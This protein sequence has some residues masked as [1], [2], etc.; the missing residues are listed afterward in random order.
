MAAFVESLLGLLA[1]K[2]P[3]S[4]PYAPAEKLFV[5]LEDATQ[6]I[7]QK[8][9]HLHLVVQNHAWVL[10]EVVEM[11]TKRNLLHAV[12]RL[13]RHEDADWACVLTMVKA[14]LSTKVSLLQTDIKHRTPL[15]YLAKY[16]E[17]HCGKD[18]G[19]SETARTLSAALLATDSS[20][21]ALSVRDFKGKSPQDY[22][23][24]LE[25]STATS[26]SSSDASPPSSGSTA[27]VPAWNQY[28]APVRREMV[29]LVCHE[30]TL[31]DSPI[32]GRHASEMA[33]SGEIE[34]ES[35]P[36]GDGGQ[37]TV[38]RG[39]RDGRVVAL[40]CVREEANEPAQA[41]EVDLMVRMLRSDSR[42][43]HPNLVEILGLVA[44]PLL[45]FPGPV[46]CVVTPFAE[47]G[48]LSAWLDRQPPGFAPMVPR[49]MVQVARGLQFLHS[50]GIVHND[51]K[52]KNVLLFPGGEEDGCLVPKL[53]DFGLSYVDRNDAYL[54]TP[55]VELSTVIYLAPER[56]FKA[57]QVPTPAS[58]MF[59]YGAT[60]WHS[61][62]RRL[63]FITSEPPGFLRTAAQTLSP[64]LPE[65]FP[66]AHP[67]LLDFINQC[68]D[69]DPEKRPT[70][71][72][73]I[74][75]NLPMVSL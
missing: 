42:C 28:A 21:A 63:P 65:A 3:S 49:L 43:P 17:A 6:S 66:G 58:D 72:D 67:V 39:I 2:N 26:P 71:F 12:V 59:S 55:V 38:Y 73:P 30:A 20:R 7:Q 74:L 61:F 50:L 33:L 52:P 56:F 37:G 32:V 60:A 51:L 44:V 9:K 31:A 57:G 45:P 53:I 40:K 41:R 70:K 1:G 8:R 64:L 23:P 4:D 24:S 15:H 18:Q 25:H 35:R 47:L 34:V 5:Q 22:S 62:H 11:E 27:R 36:I 54:R 48:D 10:P 75:V 29:K 19:P 14:L 13:L 16:Q 69:N 68:L 46:V